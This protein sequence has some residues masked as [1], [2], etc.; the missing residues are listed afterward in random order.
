MFFEN[1]L[2]IMFCE[3]LNLLWVSRLFM[4]VIEKFI[5]I[6]KLVFELEVY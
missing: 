3:E 5:V 4:G 1:F 2:F 6:F